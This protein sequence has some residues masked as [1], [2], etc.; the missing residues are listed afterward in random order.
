MKTVRMDNKVIAHFDK[1]FIKDKND[2]YVILLYK[3]SS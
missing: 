3:P 2:N 1:K